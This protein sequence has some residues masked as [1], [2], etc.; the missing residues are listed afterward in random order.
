MAWPCLSLLEGPEAFII[1]AS[2]WPPWMPPYLLK[3]L[4]YHIHSHKVSESA[5]KKLPRAVSPQ[6]G[7]LMLSLRITRGVCETQAPG[8][9]CKTSHHS[10]GSHGEPALSKHPGG[11]HA[12]IWGTLVLDVA[13]SISTLLQLVSLPLTPTSPH[14]HHRAGQVTALP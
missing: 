6:N 9:Q 7:S 14:S 13:H 10:P 8:V 2:S 11:S 5:P 3:R 12:Q 1:P 4:D